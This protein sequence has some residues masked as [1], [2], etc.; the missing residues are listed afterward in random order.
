MPRLPELLAN[1]FKHAHAQSVEIEVAI[2]DDKV[3]LVV[4]DDGR[5]IPDVA[6]LDVRLPDG[7]GIDLCRA[8]RS[9]NPGVFC[10]DAGHDGT[11]DLYA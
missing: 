8:I 2:A 6:V 9:A 10:L 3:K 5:G 1:V 4:E 7:N 11:F